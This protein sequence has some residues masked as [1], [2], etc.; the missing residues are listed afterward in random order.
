MG[1]LSSAG[2]V[3]ESYLPADIQERGLKHVEAIYYGEGVTTRKI[4]NA[5]KDMKSWP[6]VSFSWRKVFGYSFQFVDFGAT[7]YLTLY[8]RTSVSTLGRLSMS[9][10]RKH[11]RTTY[12]FRKAGH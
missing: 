2:A 7:S 5:Q 4:Q 9:V 12:N 1:V 8:P 6:G 3:L 10:G 11:G